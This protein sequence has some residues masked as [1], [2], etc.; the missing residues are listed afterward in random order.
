MPHLM[1]TGEGISSNH[2][3]KTSLTAL[4]VRIK[5]AQA[6]PQATIPNF[7]PICGCVKNL[8]QAILFL[9][10]QTSNLNQNEFASNLGP[11]PFSAPSTS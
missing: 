7:L 4:G 10:A 11:L 2:S 9:E 3:Q 1:L 8:K 5:P 6:N